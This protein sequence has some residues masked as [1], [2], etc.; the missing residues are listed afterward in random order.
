MRCE[1]Q[2]FGTGRAELRCVRIFVERAVFC[3][4]H[5]LSENG[6]IC[7]L[8]DVCTSSIIQILCTGLTL[9][10]R[11]CAINLKWIHDVEWND[12][13]WS[14]L[15][16]VSSSLIN[17]GWKKQ[18][19]KG[20][21]FKISSMNCN[22]LN[23]FK[24]RKGLFFSETNE[25]IYTFYKIRTWSTNMHILSDHVGATQCGLQNLTLTETGRPFYSTMILNTRSRRWKQPGGA[26]GTQRRADTNC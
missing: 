20:N 15:F 7:L 25:I 12:T 16:S 18:R 24:K 14:V 6:C 4:E 2:C 19:K 11:F 1:C 13:A 5:S 23:D 22:G 17:Y 26:S 10:V 8:C 21:T 9:P 3:Y